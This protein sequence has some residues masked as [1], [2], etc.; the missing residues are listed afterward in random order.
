F[1]DY[2]RAIAAEDPADVESPVRGSQML[3]TSGTTGRPKGV[4]RRQP[5]V[6]RS[7]AQSLAAGDP[8]GDRCLCTGPAYHAAPLA[9]NVASPLNAGV[10]VVMMDKWDAEETLRLIERYRITRTHMVATMFHRLLQL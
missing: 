7:A 6:Q 3:Y 4:Y 8:D 9:F 2:E 10:G 1:E 5:P